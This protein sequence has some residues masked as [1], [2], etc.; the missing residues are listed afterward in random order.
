MSEELELSSGGE[1]LKE[2]TEGAERDERGRF[3]KGNQ[4]RWPKGTSGNSAGRRDALTDTLRRRLNDPHD[5]ERT[6]RQAIIDALIDEAANG[7]VRAAALIIERLE[8]KLNSTVDLNVSRSDF[9]QYEHRVAQLMEL[10]AERK[11][12]ISRSKAIRLLSQ[13]DPRISWVLSDGG[14]DDE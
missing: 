12:P 6:K 5:S 11:M 10:A 3:T 2:R 14:E 8:G 4:H 1:P 7:S 13:S 9:Q